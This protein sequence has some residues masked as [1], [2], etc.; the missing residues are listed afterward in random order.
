MRSGRLSRGHGRALVVEFFGMP[1]AGKTFLTGEICEALEQNEKRILDFSRGT[2]I[3]RH[4][5]AW[6]HDH[7]ALRTWILRHPISAFRLWWY[8]RATGQTSANER[9]RFF[10]SWIKTIVRLRRV[11]SQYEIILMDQGFLQ[12]LWAIG[13]EAGSS[14]WDQVSSQLMR[15]MPGPDVVI[16]VRASE[17]TIVQ[18]LLR[19]EGTT[20]RIERD[21]PQ[22]QE[23]FR[24][25][26]DLT[27]QLLAGIS[28]CRQRWPDTVLLDFENDSDGCLRSSRDRISGYLERL[29]FG[30]ES[31]GTEG[32]VPSAVVPDSS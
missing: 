25:S 6:L 23:V 7:L 12:T 21:G 5:V 28:R 10:W 30:C 15:L 17:Q 18:R 29:Q 31:V 20:S 13:Y 9:K 32:N 4:S 8:I 16:T 1:G 11:R 19:R 2:S 26:R 14:R 22:R 24:R 27:D 3:R